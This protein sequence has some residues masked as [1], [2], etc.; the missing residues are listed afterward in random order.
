MPQNVGIILFDPKF[1]Y[2]LLMQGRTALAA[3]GIVRLDKI[4]F[5]TNLLRLLE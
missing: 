5:C 1:C 2:V 3:Q 4:C